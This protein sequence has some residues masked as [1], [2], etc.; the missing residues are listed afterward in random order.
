MDWLFSWKM[1]LRAGEWHSG[2][3]RRGGNSQLCV[4]GGAKPR[5]RCTCRFGQCFCCS[6]TDERWYMQMCRRGRDY[7]QQ[8][9]LKGQEG[10]AVTE[11]QLSLPP[12]FVEVHAR[13]CYTAHILCR[14]TR[15][16]ERIHCALSLCKYLL[17]GSTAACTFWLT[18]QL[19]VPFVWQHSCVYLLSG[20][21]AVF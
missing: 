17:S 3:K 19:H 9:R 21:T 18:A 11:W 4:P 10:T 2:P 7:L 16:E 20:S 8:D 1:Y 6:K 13:L 14:D 5:L 12:F 15:F